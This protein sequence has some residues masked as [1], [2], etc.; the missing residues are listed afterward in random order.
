MWPFKTKQVVDGGYTV[1]DGASNAKVAEVANM[2]LTINSYA[3]RSIFSYILRLDVNDALREL[4]EDL[5]V[6]LVQ[7]FLAGTSPILEFVYQKTDACPRC[8]PTYFF[9]TRSITFTEQAKYDLRMTWCFGVAMKIT[10]HYAD[11]TKP[12]KKGGKKRARK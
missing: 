2:E 6:T 4:G 8:D 5:E 1:V 7:P 12:K 10:Q 9:A 11:E 3:E